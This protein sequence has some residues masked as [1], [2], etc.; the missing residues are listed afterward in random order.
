MDKM[1]YSDEGLCVEEVIVPNGF[2]FMLL[3]MLIFK[4]CDYLFM[5]I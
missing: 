3:V 5:V 1:L 4:F 2:D